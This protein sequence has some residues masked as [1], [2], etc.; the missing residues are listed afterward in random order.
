[1]I[2]PKKI[3]AFEKFAERWIELVN[4]YGDARS[5]SISCATVFSRRIFPYGNMLAPPPV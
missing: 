2:D 5:T 3:D 1:V 4:R